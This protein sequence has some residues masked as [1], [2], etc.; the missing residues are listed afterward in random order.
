MPQPKSLLLISVLLMQS[1]MNTDTIMRSWQG[2]HIEELMTNWGAPNTH[3]TLESG[4]AVYSWVSS[5]GS[6]YMMNTCRQTFVTNPEGIIV[7]WRFAG[8]PQWQSNTST[9]GWF[10]RSKSNE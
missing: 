7:S 4:K 5:W 10:S 6:A 3:S 9:A 2:R 8:C 1:C